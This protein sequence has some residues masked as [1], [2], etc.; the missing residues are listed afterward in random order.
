MWDKKQPETI[1][2]IIEVKDLVYEYPDFRALHGISFKIQEGSISALVGPNGAG[3]TTLLKCLAALYKP[4]SGSVNI[5]GVDV[6]ADPRKGHEYIGFQSD[7]FGLYYELTPRQALQYFAEAYNIPDN[8][9]DKRIN[10]VLYKLGLSNKIDA[11]IMTL[12]RGMRQRMAIAQAIIHEPK[13]LLMDEP[14]SGLDPEKRQALAHL[15]KELNEQGMTIMVSS[16]ILSE[17]DD[18]ANHL[19]ILNNGNIIQG[20]ERDVE[21]EK[22]LQEVQIRLLANTANLEEAIKSIPFVRS[23]EI[24]EKLVNLKFKGDLNDQENILRILVSKGIP[25]HAFYLRETNLQ[26]E[27]LELINK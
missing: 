8:N 1:N 7:F 18:Y 2:Y 5:N 17:L 24:K 13:V 6:L 16:H 15:F 26:E 12:S 21:V 20:K 4:Y 25:I 3:K 14:A 22:D 9:I 27:Y 11:K 10:E 23:Y 19:I